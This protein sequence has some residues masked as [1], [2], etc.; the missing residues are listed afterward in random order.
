MNKAVTICL[1]IVGII[2]FIPVVGVLSAR[3]L[4][5]AYSISLVGN[6]LIILMRHRAL[7]FGVIGGFILYSAF[8]Q[9]YQSAAMLIAAFSM[10]GYVVLVML[11]GDYNVSIFKVLIADIVG[12][13]VLLLGAVFKYCFK[14]S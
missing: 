11:V 6:D 7:L 5:S 10:V 4:E 1:I 14:S 2:N 9:P 12:L 13:G 3:N 8:Y